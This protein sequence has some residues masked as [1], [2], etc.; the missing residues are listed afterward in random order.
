M[1]VSTSLLSAPAVQA[2]LLAIAG[3]LAYWLK[4]IPGLLV[5]WVKRFFISSLTIDSRDDF[6]FSALVEYMDEHPALRSVNQFTAHSVRSGSQYQNLEEDLRNGQ[7]PRAVLSP[8]EGVHIVMIEG[9]LIWLRREVQ[10]GQSIFEKVTLAHFGRSAEFLESF[11]QSA[12][13]TRVARE[14]DTLSVYVPNPFHGG[15]WTR[16]RLGS[17]R[18]LSSVANARLCWPICRLFSKGASVMPSW[19]F[20]GAEVICSMGHPAAAKH[21]W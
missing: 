1:D 15:D 5:S 16:A 14:T 20:L 9:R 19:A 12:I 3:A 10:V 2:A 21:R 17:R 13:N 11:L 18:P 7:P 6:L 8:S 4:D